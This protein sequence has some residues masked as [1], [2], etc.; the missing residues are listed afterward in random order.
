MSLFAKIILQ[1]ILIRFEFAF[2]V[3][4]STRVTCSFIKL[5]LIE[6]STLINKLKMEKSKKPI[7]ECLLCEYQ[8]G[9]NAVI[10]TQ[11][12]TIFLPLNFFLDIF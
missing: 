6:S 3:H 11:N 4:L 1:L 10:A 2:N 7:R 9:N 5:Y 12:N 8:L